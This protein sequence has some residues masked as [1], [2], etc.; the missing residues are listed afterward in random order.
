MEI[1]IVRHAEA[2]ERREGLA[3]EMRH[4]TCRGRKQ[5]EKQAKRLKKAGVKPDLIM[6]S[7]LIRAV[8]TAEFLA[9]RIGKDAVV[10]AH[11][12]LSPD[13]EVETLMKMLRHSGKLHSIMLVGHEPLISRFAASVL[14]LEQVPPFHKSSCMSLTFNP[15]KPKSRATFNWY[16]QC[17]KKTVKSAKKA[18]LKKQKG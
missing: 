11:G 16:A 2:L 18:L 4:L 5:A 15:E 1:Y 3:E 10:A 13:S 14:G 12:S 17:G 7:P 6:T 8:Q 9:A